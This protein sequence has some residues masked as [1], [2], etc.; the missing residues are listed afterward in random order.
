MLKRGF[1]KYFLI[2]TFGLPGSAT[3][4]DPVSR[5]PVV[6]GQIVQT[7]AGEEIAF[8]ERQ[9]LQALDVLQDVKAGDVIRTNAFG[10]IALLFADRTQI[11]LGRNSVLLVKELRADGGIS[12]DLQS[13]RMFGRAARG[14]A[15]VTIDTP[16]AAAA[17][18]GTDWTLA[19]AGNRTT[20]SV[21]EGLVELSNRQGNIAVSNGESAVATLGSAPS[22]TVIVGADIREQMLYNLSLRTVFSDPYVSAADVR[23]MDSEQDYFTSRPKGQWTNEDQVLAAEL[24]FARREL[25]AAAQQIASARHLRL[26]TAQKARLSFL[27]GR[28]VADSRHYAQAAVLFDQAERALDDERQVSARYLSYF[29]KSL[30]NPTKIYPAPLANSA[31][32]ASVMGEELMAA[33]LVSPRQALQILKSNESRFGNDVRY[34]VA[35]ANRALL[36]SDFTAA[37]LAIEKAEAMDPQDAAFHD[38]RASYRS[39]VQGNMQG[40]MKDQKDAV[41]RDPANWQYWNN[42]ALLEGARRAVH[43]AEAAFKHA[44]ALA[45]NAPEPMANYAELLLSSGRNDEA[46]DLINRALAI[47]PAFDVALF[48]RGRQK[49]Q[50]GHQNDALQDMLK[51]TSA[52]PT[53]GAG[54]LKL[55][56]TYAASGDV[57]S[58]AQSFELADRLDPL[59]PLPA[60]YRA[61]LAFDQYQLD[62]AIILAQESVRRMRARGGDYTSVEASDD[63]GS[64]LGGIYRTASLDAWG[65]YWGD[66]AFDPFQGASY[67]DQNL[68]GSVRPYFTA[69]GAVAVGEPSTGNDAAFS[70]YVQGLML[71]PLA[72]ASPKMHASFFRVPFHEMEIGSGVTVT[73]SDAGMSGF[74]SYQTLGYDPLPYALSSSLIYSHF[75]P[76]YADQ[77]AQNLNSSTTFGFEITPQDRIVGHLNAVHIEG[78]VSYDGVALEGL[79]ITR[80]DTLNADGL[81]GF[82]GWSHTF[83]FHNVLSAGLFGSV[84]DRSGRDA[85]FAF[86]PDVGRDVDVEEDQHSLKGGITHLVEITDGFTIRYGGETGHIEST[87]SGTITDYLLADPSVYVRFP[88][89]RIAVEGDTSRA[90]FGTMLSLSQSLEL[91]ATLFA[92]RVRQNG[93]SS[94]ALSPHIGLAWETAEGNYIRA[95]FIE[96]MP[97][98]ERDTLA[99]IATVGLRADAVPDGSGKTDTTIVRW[100]AEWTQRLFTSVEY[101]HQEVENLALSLP[102]YVGS[103]VVPEATFDRL[104][105]TGNL[106]IGGGLTAFANYSHIWSRGDVPETADRLPTVPEHVARVGLSYTSPARI[107]FTIAETYLGERTSFP[108]PASPSDFSQLDG[109]F[110]TDIA[111]SWESED[112]HFSVSLAVSNLFDANAEV[113]PLIP[114]A[115]RTISATIQGRF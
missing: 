107:R 88:G 81:N 48:Q 63:F 72:I 49:L 16:A 28:L 73:G 19:V 18:R 95:A 105:V 4:A 25:D 66:R 33:V 103:F 23:K 39:Y 31:S 60:Q 115:K 101:Q 38:A 91:E 43:E 114:A 21:I 2:A 6:S 70:G 36:A 46:H 34:Q 102:V 9:S 44:I 90:W 10:Q 41:H 58:A 52:N 97:L 7:R 61:L 47:D 78:G 56:A 45:P 79:D 67:F 30:S 84:I 37:A 8:V 93:M 54:L 26:S 5:S 22:R 1:I 17:I 100:D 83:A 69:P 29:A 82:L 27:E 108:D 15:G 89:N 3:H 98:S 40:A 74:A 32:L 75:N 53:Y 24:A 104:S 62:D 59:S 14:G 12:L 51:A 96:Q 11:R 55:G 77:D 85:L 71:D 42:L 110:L 87:T 99:P 113:A 20:L 57:E 64:T 65:R 80:R 13:G 111:A 50:T 76:S 92:E 106:W 109:A 35:I 94:N 112:R 68:S 86:S